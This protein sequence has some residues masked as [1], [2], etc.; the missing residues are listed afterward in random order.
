MTVFC[1]TKT[2]WCLSAVQFYI[3]TVTLRKEERGTGTAF[4]VFGMFVPYEFRYGHLA[5]RGNPKFLVYIYIHIHTV[6]PA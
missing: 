5:K 6:K 4:G 1:V 2:V 3:I